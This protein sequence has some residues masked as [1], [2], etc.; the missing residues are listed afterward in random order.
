LK[1]QD[2]ELIG[3]DLSRYLGDVSSACLV[4]QEIVNSVVNLCEVYTLGF[5]AMYNNHNDGD[6]SN[7]T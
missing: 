3:C 6:E 2:R 1:V 7:D 5:L 4:S